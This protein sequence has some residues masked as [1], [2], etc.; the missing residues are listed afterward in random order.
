L[1]CFTT[2]AARS[3]DGGV[4]IIILKFGKVVE[5]SSLNR[6]LEARSDKLR[7]SLGITSV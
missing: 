1:K 2:G 4:A 5:H 7:L 3:R 6:D